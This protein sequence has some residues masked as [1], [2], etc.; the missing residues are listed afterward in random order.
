MDAPLSSYRERM[1][2]DHKGLTCHMYTV[3][4]VICY[5]PSVVIRLLID[6]RCEFAA[7]WGRSR[8]RYLGRNSEGNRF[9][10][11]VA[12]W[13]GVIFIWRSDEM[14]L[15]DILFFTYRRMQELWL[16][17]W[18][19]LLFICLMSDRGEK[20]E[21]VNE[22]RLNITGENILR[23]LHNVQQSAACITF[24]THHWLPCILIM[25]DL[26]WLPDK[27]QSS[28]L[29][30]HHNWNSTRLPLTIPADL[31]THL[32]FSQP[33]LIRVGALWKGLFFNLAQL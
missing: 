19:Q 11:D 12:L 20:K 30:P 26:H 28:M 33:V 2:C 13:L 17:K 6:G 9:I 3:T 23:D 24:R 21:S 5:V 29:L 22:T 32:R 10:T 18:M 31:S 7:R 1:P 27:V 8:S 14:D 4:C 16:I 15:W 25:K